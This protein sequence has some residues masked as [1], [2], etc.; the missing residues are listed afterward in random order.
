MVPPVYKSPDPV[1]DPDTRPSVERFPC[2]QGQLAAVGGH[3]LH[4]TK[5]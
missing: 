5:L 1:G 2:R 4:Q 3:Q